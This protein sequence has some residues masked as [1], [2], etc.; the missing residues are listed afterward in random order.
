MIAPEE[1]ARPT[2]AGGDLVGD[3]QHVVLV[4]QPTN[5]GEVRG[6]VEAHA[7]GALHDRLEDH[8]S[9]LT[10]VRFEQ[11]C[12]LGDVG[13]SECLA[14]GGFGGGREELRGEHPGEHRVHAVDRV[15]HRHAG[16]R[17]AVIAVAHGEQPRP[18]GSPDASC[19]LQRHLDGHLD[20]HRTRIGKEHVLESGGAQIDETLAQLDRPRM[21][22]PAEHDM[23]HLAELRPHGLVEDRVPVAVDR[24]PPRRHA[25]DGIASVGEPQPRPL[26]AH[27]RHRRQRRRHRRVRVP[28]AGAI[29]RDELSRR[30]DHREVLDTRRPQVAPPLITRRSRR[31]GSR[32]G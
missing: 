16:E 18:L 26:G 12:E 3:Q 14:E 5:G 2:E 7:A 9:D 13:G 28:D 21:G 25:V 30:I 31:S 20:R 6:S 15:A 10:V 4:A 24:R 17:V 11:G 32:S 29:A 1:L 27:D 22:D 23:S 8:G 19:V